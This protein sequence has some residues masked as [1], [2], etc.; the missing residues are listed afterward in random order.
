MNRRGGFQVRNGSR[1]G[2]GRAGRRGGTRPSRSHRRSSRAKMAVVWCGL[3]VEALP[4]A[5]AFLK[6][7]RKKSQLT[8]ARTS[9]S[10]TTREGRTLL[11]LQN[12][13]HETIQCCWNRERRNEN[14]HSPTRERRFWLV[15]NETSPAILPLV[16]VLVSRTERER[17]SE[18]KTRTTVP[19]SVDSGNTDFNNPCNTSIIRMGTRS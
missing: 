9:P 12:D 19:R 6:V 4:R 10:E 7:W 14:D 18:P 17:R 13:A 1:S 16:L 8:S 2:L 3:P 15:P 11:D 5:C